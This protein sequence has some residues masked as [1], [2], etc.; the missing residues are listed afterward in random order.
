MIAGLLAA[1]ILIRATR[2]DRDMYHEPS[3]L[4]VFLM[5]IAGMVALLIA[6]VGFISAQ[7]WY[8]DCQDRGYFLSTS[9]NRHAHIVRK[10]QGID[11]KGNK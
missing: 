4:M 2:T 11:K 6:I 10:L 7:N 8:K 9:K 5:V 1:W 3:I